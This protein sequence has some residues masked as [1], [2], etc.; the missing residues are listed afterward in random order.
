[1]LVVEEAVALDRKIKVVVVVP[2]DIEQL[3]DF[4]LL[5]VLQLL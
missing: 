1:L 5:L 2:V 3:Q 4:L